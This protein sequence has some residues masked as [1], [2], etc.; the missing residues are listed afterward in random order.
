MN[1]INPK[2]SGILLHPTALPSPWGMGDLGP[3]AFKFIDDL[4]EMDQSYWQI[5]PLGP[6]DDSF[7]PYYGEGNSDTLCRFASYCFCNRSDARE[8]SEC[9]S[10]ACQ[11]V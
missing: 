9:S 6:L 10:M 5:L 7:S 2:V 3:Q 4:V 11:R 8:G 1:N